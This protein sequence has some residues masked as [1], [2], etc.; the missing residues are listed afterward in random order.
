MKLNLLFPR[1]NGTVN[2]QRPQPPTGLLTLGAYLKKVAPKVEVKV[3][4]ANAASE[5]IIGDV[6]NADIIGISTWFSNYD[7]GIVS[8]KQIR[9]RNPSAMIVLGGPHAGAIPRRVLANNSGIDSVV[10]GDGEKAI[11]AI[12]RGADPTSIPGLTYRDGSM[13]KTNPADYSLPLGDIPAFTLDN[14]VTPFEW[15]AQTNG[16]LSSFPISQFRGCFRIKRCNYC[17]LPVDGTRKSNPQ[18][19]WQQV[20]VL[21]ERYGIDSFFETADIFPIKLARRLADA[22]PTSLKD[23]QFRV[24][25]YPGMLRAKPQYAKDLRDMGVTTAFMGVENV[26]QFPDSSHFQKGYNRSFPRGYTTTDLIQEIRVLGD[27]GIRV[28]PGFVLGLP[29]ETRNSLAANKE[30]IQEITE[31][32]NVREVSISPVIPLPGSAYFQKAITNQSV[33]TEYKALAF[34]DLKRTDKINYKLLTR[35]FTSQFTK[36]EPED[37]INVV[38]AITGIRVAH[39]GY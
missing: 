34:E 16:A 12:V 29:G 4:D 38:Q 19:F 17:S 22:K 36:V 27:Y 31:L 33:L 3:Y 37:V 8:T 24:Y 30:L 35:L 15:I 7:A 18:S 32:E 1:H 10:S 26:R 11:A 21:H 13:I 39:F 5:N 23:I 14:L 6:T 28:M 25:I 20:R 9:E 2:I